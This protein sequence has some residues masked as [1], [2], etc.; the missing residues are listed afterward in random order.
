MCSTS[1][2]VASQEKIWP[3]GAQCHSSS[4]GTLVPACWS[5]SVK[6]PSQIY[7]L[8][9]RVKNILWGTQMSS[10]GRVAGSCRLVFNLLMPIKS[11]A[12]FIQYQ[13]IYD[14]YMSHCIFC[15]FFLLISSSFDF[16]FTWPVD[17]FKP[18]QRCTDKPFRLCVSDVFKGE[19][20]S[21]VIV[22]TSVSILKILLILSR[23]GLGLLCN[24]EDWGWF[25]SDW[26]QDTGNASQ[27]N[28][29][30]QRYALV[31]ICSQFGPGN[32]LWNY[33]NK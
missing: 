2:P 21:S 31:F 28:V 33:E 24:W 30:S 7:F 10:P 3:P 11:E 16:L 27:W 19:C 32:T 14:K 29:H 13:R 22:D 5:R 1:P 4:P 9:V 6:Y 23:P 8:N 26:W 12:W 17:A 18:P 25:C 15:C 20:Q